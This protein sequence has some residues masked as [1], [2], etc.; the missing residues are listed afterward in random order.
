MNFPNIACHHPIHIPN[1]DKIGQKTSGGS[2]YF[3][4]CMKDGTIK[5]ELFGRFRQFLRT[6]FGAYKSTHLNTVRKRLNI[7]EGYSHIKA[8]MKSIWERVHPPF[9]GRS[10]SSNIWHG[11]GMPTSISKKLA[12]LRIRQNDGG[13][14]DIPTLVRDYQYL[15]IPGDGHC[16]FRSVA[17]GILLA[18]QQ[19]DPRT[20]G[21][22]F[23]HLQ[24]QIGEINQTLG[25]NQSNQ[26]QLV[27][28][29]ESYQQFLDILAPITN[30]EDQ[31]LDLN[32]TEVNQLYKIM[33]NRASSDTLV[34][35]L[36]NLAC[37]YN[38]AH[39]EEAMEFLAGDIDYDQYFRKLRTSNEMGDHPELAALSKAMNL[40]LKVLNVE[41][42]VGGGSIDAQHN[43]H[44][45]P[46]AALGVTVLR[47]PLHY[48]LAIPRGE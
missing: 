24:D 15:Q 4:R 1:E 48:D 37:N 5:V 8:T 11:L 17:G 39:L 22:F 34:Q 44:G 14:F 33:R 6:V 3:L 10:S 42:L 35:F 16:M 40:R 38:Q 27:D 19:A 2:K 47:T 18:L 43:F 41:E 36:R 7:V 23:E 46:D 21:Q 30:Q 45:G 29:N 25:E 28:L 20:R 32:Q 9:S 26:S 31:S 13:A 12:D